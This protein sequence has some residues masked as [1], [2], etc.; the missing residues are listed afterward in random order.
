MYEDNIMTFAALSDLN[1][2][3]SC[4]AWGNLAPDGGGLIVHDA[5]YGMFNLFNSQNGF[6]SFAY[7][8]HTMT[9][10][11]KGN[12]AGTYAV[13]TRI[14]EM[15]DMCVEAGL[16]GAVDF[17]N[18][19]LI[20]DDNCPNDYNPGQEDGDGD[21][22]GDVCDDC[23]EMSGDVNDDFIIDILDIVSVVNMV[24]TGGINSS[25]FTECAKSD[26]DMT[27]DGTINILD[28][29]QIINAVLGNLNQYAVS[30]EYLDVTSSVKNGNLY[31]TFSSDVA[32]GLELTFA[33]DVSAVNLVDN[34]N[35][36][37]VSNLGDVNKSVLYSMHNKTFDKLTVEIENGS[38]L[39]IKD[40]NIIAGDSN[41]Q[42]MSVRW[43]SSEIHNFALTNLYPNPFN[44]VTT[45]DY[46]VD[47]AGQLRLSVF[48]VLGQE[49]AVLKNGYVGEGAYQSVWDA[50]MLSSGVYYVNM[51]MH[52][53]VETMKA[54]LV[55]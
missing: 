20:D 18:D 46:S 22:L 2:P 37:L 48:N 47:R 35:F 33:G 39:D 21:G 45:I 4:T 3:Y 30:S 17:D 31:L 34:N 23:H 7:L 42:E 5:G 10:Y 15:L 28:V 52:G 11:S 32:S 6:P 13:K 40:I 25:D 50:S 24:L 19:G 41:G 1:Q 12:S 29:I 14:Q 43:E 55:K 51:I 9:V 26:A 54:V 16:C 53:Q 44:P 49:V 8:D 38:K 36:I 27:G